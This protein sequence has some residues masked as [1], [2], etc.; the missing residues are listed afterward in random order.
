MKVSA[1]L[2]QLHDADKNDWCLYKTPGGNAYWS[3]RRRWSEDYVLATPGDFAE[4]QGWT[5]FGWERFTDGDPMWDDVLEIEVEL[6][7]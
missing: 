6:K 2:L 4:A 5:D 3:W 7:E 1:T